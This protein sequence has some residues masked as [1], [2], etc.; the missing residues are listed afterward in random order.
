MKKVSLLLVIFS[1]IF[2]CLNV[3]AKDSVISMNKYREE[4]FLFIDDSYNKEGKVDGKIVG[5]YYLK[6]G[7]ED[8]TSSADKQII[9]LKYNNN[10]KVI[11]TYSYGKTKEDYLD[12]LT[13][14]YSSDGN[15]DGYLISMVET[16]DL[17]ETSSNETIFIKVDLDG[18]FV[19]E[20][21]LSLNKNIVINKMIPIRGERVEYLLLGSNEEEGFVI[22]LDKDL[23]VIWQENSKTIYKDITLI[24]DN[25]NIVGY[26]LIKEIQ[27]EDKKVSSLVRYNLNG[28][29]IK[30]IKDNLDEYNSCYLEE[31]N[32][33]FIMY[34]TT[35]LVKLKNGD[36]SYYIIN[37]N[38]K[39]EDYFE[40][41]GD[42]YVNKDKKIVLFP[43]IKEGKIKE[44]L[45]GYSNQK[46]KN[47]EIVKIAVDGEIKEK[48]KKIYD[49][50][51]TISDFTFKKNTLYLVGQINCPEDDNCDYDSNSLLLIST[52][53]KVIEVKDNDSKNILIITTIFIILICLGVFIKK[54]KIRL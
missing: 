33:G 39:N 29:E 41:I 24:K 40:T 18:K 22:K 25:N 48:I 34:G 52:E 45:L 16:H 54:K 28:E 38:S 27:Q 10:G 1:F 12:Y 51:Y 11:W 32:D 9:L 8:E 30:I 43:I 7:E 42:I 17:G 3:N 36:T 14:S 2:Y 50:Y 44:Y 35:S 5:G 6:E 4:N 31:A 37:Y 46:S 19:S 15:I 13:Y 53:D 49:E 23:N 20:K 21:K 26:A 47:L